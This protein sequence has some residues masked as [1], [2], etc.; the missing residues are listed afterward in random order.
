[1][2]TGHDM[3]SRMREQRIIDVESTD[4]GGNALERSAS[5][6][7]CHPCQLKG[8]PELFD[9]LG[10]FQNFEQS[11]VVRRTLAGEALVSKG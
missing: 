3:S 4:R 9:D 10:L 1:M 8:R 6:V 11:E 7:P 5:K 2:Q